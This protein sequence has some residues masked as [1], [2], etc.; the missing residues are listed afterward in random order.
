MAFGVKMAAYSSGGALAAAVALTTVRAESGV[1]YELK[2][3]WLRPL[4][5]L[6]FRMLSDCFR[7]PRRKLRARLSRSRQREIQR[8]RIQSRK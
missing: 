1:R 7:R 8:T 2:K 6:P 3:S 4:A 5:P